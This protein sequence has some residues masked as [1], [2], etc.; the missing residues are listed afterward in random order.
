HDLRRR[1]TTLAADQSVQCFQ[2]GKISFRS[3]QTLR[4]P[5]HGKAMA[6]VTP[7]QVLQEL[8]DQGRL[9]NAWLPGHAH[10]LSL[11]L[12]GRIETGLQLRQLRLPPHCSPLK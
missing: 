7:R 12:G 11:A 4:T 1:F 3:R 10:D 6:R 5:S 8:R 2:N 9:A